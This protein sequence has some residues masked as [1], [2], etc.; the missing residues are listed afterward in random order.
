MMYMYFTANTCELDIGDFLCVIV[1]NPG[2]LPCKSLE[3]VRQ[4]GYALG[5]Q[6]VVVPDQMAGQSDE[7][8]TGQAA[9]K[10]IHYWYTT[11][12]NA[13]ILHL[14]SALARL[15]SENHKA[16]KYLVNRLLDL[17]IGTLYKI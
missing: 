13:P 5:Q 16:L 17:G 15:L 6:D 3:A 8:T 11:R 4:F 14:V 7:Y 12:H 10:I 1:D 9:N 2:S